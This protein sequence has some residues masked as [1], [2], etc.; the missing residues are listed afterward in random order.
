M[1]NSLILLIA[2]IVV[3]AFAT[4]MFCY[5]VNYNEVAVVTTFD[6]AIAPTYDDEGRM[7]D[8]GSVRREPGLAFRW[9]WPIQG[10]TKYSTR[11]QVLNTPKIEVQLAGG[12]AVVVSSYITWNVEDPYLFFRSLNT[13][14]NAIEQLRTLV[15]DA[16]SVISQYRLEDM[17]NEN[18]ERIRLRQLADEALAHLRA[19][20]R[21]NGYG[22]AVTDFGITRIELPEMVTQS[23]FE[24]IKADRNS[25]AQRTRSQGEAEAEEIVSR[26]ENARRRIESFANSLARQIETAGEREAARFY[27][28][29]SDPEDQRLAIMLNRIDTLPNIVGRRATLVLGSDQLGLDQ[30]Y[31]DWLRELARPAAA[32]LTG[33]R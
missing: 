11:K 23:V 10:V 8:S 14:R 5:Q 2:G 31:P 22:I 21:A 26:A 4:Y 17:V 3:I 30:L 12:Q 24:R 19:A 7:I 32:D 20:T 25:L 33:E 9:P 28:I 27:S 13:K 29:F 15:K 16:N 18:P 1:K 6:Q